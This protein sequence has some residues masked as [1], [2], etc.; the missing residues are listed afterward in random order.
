MAI[1]FKSIKSHFT[2][3]RNFNE[4]NVL[5]ACFLCVKPVNARKIITEAIRWKKLFIRYLNKKSFI[6][7][8]Q[9][10]KAT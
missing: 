4:E 7:I 1:A 10:K 6:L 5:I 3:W 2:R 9:R 8:N